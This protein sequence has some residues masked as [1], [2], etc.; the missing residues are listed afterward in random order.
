MF[1]IKIG[2]DIFKGRLLLFIVKLNRI[3]GWFWIL[4]K[5]I[6]GL[7][8]IFVI[9]LKVLLIIYIVFCIVK[10]ILIMFCVMFDFINFVYFLLLLFFFIFIFKSFKVLLLFGNINM[11]V[12][13]WGN[14]CG[15]YWLN[16]YILKLLVMFLLF[17]VL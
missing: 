8:F 1:V 10:F 14:F 15:M 5:E 12:F 6:I 2:K 16:M 9:G 3:D 13:F 17:W 11:K 7:L 4:L